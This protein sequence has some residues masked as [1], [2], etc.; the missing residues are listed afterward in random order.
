[1]T[2]KKTEETKKN[3]ITIKAS[4]S[5][6]VYFDKVIEVSDDELPTIKENAKAWAELEVE[7]SWM[8]EIEKAGFPDDTDIQSVKLNGEEML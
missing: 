6:T 5:V 8:E 3:I 1:M 2:T 7:D 4:V